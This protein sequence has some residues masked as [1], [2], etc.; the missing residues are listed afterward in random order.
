MA[1]WE[2]CDD[3]E[4][5]LLISERHS[6]LHGLIKKIDLREYAGWRQCQVDLL[7]AQKKW[8]ASRK[9]VSHGIPRCK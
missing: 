2:S 7:M 1:W 9:D 5:L 8:Q 6:K 4:S 3:D